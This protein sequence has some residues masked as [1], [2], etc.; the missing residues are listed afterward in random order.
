MQVGDHI[1]CKRF[2]GAYTH[3][4][5]YVGNNLVVHY[6]DGILQ[7]DSLEDFTKGDKVH[8]MSR[9]KGDVSRH[10]SVKRALNSVGKEDYDVRWRNCETFARWCCENK[11]ESK[12][13][14][15]TIKDDKK[16]DGNTF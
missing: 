10:K 3:H 1:Y 13:M 9:K 15:I 5:V 16:H 11:A 7:R 12:Q 6:R 4:G 8:V 2:L 14:G